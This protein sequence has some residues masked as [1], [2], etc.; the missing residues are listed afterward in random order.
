MGLN[1]AYAVLLK[2]YFSII[3]CSFQRTSCPTNKPVPL[4]FAKISPQ[5]APHFYE[6]PSKISTADKKVNPNVAP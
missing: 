6:K 2:E 3:L 1:F 4:A 5:D